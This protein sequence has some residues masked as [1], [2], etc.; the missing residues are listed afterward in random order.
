[1][2]EALHSILRN[3]CE[4]F[5]CTAGHSAAPKLT[6][7]YFYQ[8]GVEEGSYT[9]H[10]ILNCM[11]RGIFRAQRSYLAGNY[12]HSPNNHFWR[13]P[14]RA[15]PA[16]WDI[17]CARVILS[18]ADLLTYTDAAQI[19]TCSSVCLLRETVRLRKCSLLR[20]SPGRAF[21]NACVTDLEPSNPTDP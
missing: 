10:H 21:M 14:N 2:S 11:L 5:Q 8:V 13:N 16:T 6:D 9:L 7:T 4:D 20:N 1:M 18:L 15:R 3:V 12:I 17:P 19:S